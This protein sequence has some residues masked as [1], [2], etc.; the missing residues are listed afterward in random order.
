MEHFIIVALCYGQQPIIVEIDETSLKQQPIE[1]K[2]GKDDDS[3]HG[4]Y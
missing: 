4:N 1:Q 2:L 3:M